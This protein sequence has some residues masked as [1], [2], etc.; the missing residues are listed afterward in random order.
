MSFPD[1]VHSAATS[2]K[3][4]PFATLAIEDVPTELTSGTAPVS[5]AAGVSVSGRST[6][7]M[8]YS[9]AGAPKT[10]FLVSTSLVATQSST[11]A[12]Q[13]STMATA[14]CNIAPTLHSCALPAPQQASDL[15]PPTKRK[16]VF[17]V[18]M[19]NEIDSPSPDNSEISPHSSM[20]NL[21]IEPESAALSQVPPVLESVRSLSATSTG[22][23]ESKSDSYIDIHHNMVGSGVCIGGGPVEFGVRRSSNITPESM[24]S[25]TNTGYRELVSHSLPIVQ[26]TSEGLDRPPLPPQQAAYCRNITPSSEATL[27][28]QSLLVRNVPPDMWGGGYYHYN[29]APQSHGVSARQPIGT[30]TFYPPATHT[31]HHGQQYVPQMRVNQ[32]DQPHVRQVITKPVKPVVVEE[33][34]L[35]TVAAQLHQLDEQA[36][37]TRQ[38]SL[39][40]EQQMKSSSARALTIHDFPQAELLSQAFMQFMYSMSTV[41]RDPTYQPLID[42]LD[43][44]F[45]GGHHVTKPSSA[46]PTVVTEPVKQEGEDKTGG[47][48]RSSTHPASVKYDEDDD[49][50]LKSIMMK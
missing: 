46:P 3:V 11:V 7:G 40:T 20:E 4:G 9:L 23:L 48:A 16:K 47:G 25:N 43:K 30:D 50:H 45:G 27:K 13:S 24:P 2:S 37:K 31:Y 19:V 6:E 28:D 12:T 49:G 10:T 29:T 17:E 38:S 41:F 34:H 44:H 5:T 18:E 14:T 36:S 1:A 22:P 21:T 8:T 15:A 32:P 33:V 42:S 39:S 35:P 26:Q